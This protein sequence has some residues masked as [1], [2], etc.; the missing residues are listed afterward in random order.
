MK[1]LKDNFYTV[2]KLW[3][4]QFA[5]IFLGVLILLPSAGADTPKWLMPVASAF[6]AVFYLVLLFWSSCELGLQHSVSIEIGKMK[7]DPL[8]GLILS[9]TA[10]LPV[11]VCTVIACISKAFIAGVP[12]FQSPE[13]AE[14]LAANVYAISTTINELLHM[15]YKGLLIFFDLN[16]FPFIHLPIALLSIGVCT[17]AYLA[18]TKGFCASLFAKRRED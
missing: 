17:L 9:L 3:V 12:Y 11:L 1:I 16:R 13:G 7:R 2:V 14:G 10:N 4:N 15:M 8:V 6:T 18:G 5:M